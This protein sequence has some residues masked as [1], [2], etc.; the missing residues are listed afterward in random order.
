MEETTIYD[1]LNQAQ[2]RMTP[3]TVAQGVSAA[4]PMSVAG[5]FTANILARE[6]NAD[7]TRTFVPYRTLPPQTDYVYGADKLPLA[8]TDDSRLMPARVAGP[9]NQLPVWRGWRPNRPRSNWN[10]LP[11][12]ILSPQQG[13]GIESTIPQ[14]REMVN[15]ADEMAEGPYPT[16]PE[17]MTITPEVQNQKGIHLESPELYGDNAMNGMGDDTSWVSDDISTIAKD[18]ASSIQA[19]YAPG[20]IKPPTTA[21]TGVPWGTLLLVGGIGAAAIYFLPKL[22][23]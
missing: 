23:K 3:T 21:S 2:T 18:I 14:E 22:M 5:A 16:L 10:D 17:T 11:M 15:R 6:G 20:T 12:Q 13:P 4:Q 19:K 7:E 1:L 9:P 8:K